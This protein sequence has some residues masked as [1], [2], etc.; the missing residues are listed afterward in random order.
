MKIPEEHIRDA[1]EQRML[2]DAI[3]SAIPSGT[4]AISAIR[5]LVSV[6]QDYTDYLR[7][8][9]EMRAEEEGE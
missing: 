5:A 9:D 7:D 4:R 8:L 6:L 2:K 3:R 1:N